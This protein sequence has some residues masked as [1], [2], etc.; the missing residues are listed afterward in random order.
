MSGITDAME[1]ARAGKS[2]LASDMLRNEFDRL[3]TPERMVELCEWLAVCFEGLEDYEQAA[4]WY[5]TAGQYI[6]SEPR[7]RYPVQEMESLREYEKALECYEQ[8]DD[9]EGI[10]R[11]GAMMAD[12]RRSCASS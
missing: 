6:L 8:I 2:K 10:Q 3:N 4:S 1:L 5:E 12:L 7:A 9:I 11:C